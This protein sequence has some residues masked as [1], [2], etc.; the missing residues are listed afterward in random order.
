MSDKVYIVT[1]GC[2]SD[3]GIDAVFKDKSKA[4]LYCDCHRGSIIEE[5]D[6]MDDNVFTP[7]NIMNITFEIE[8]NGIEKI[9]LS[10]DRVVKENYNHI[11][12]VKHVLAF[13]DHI[14]ISLC[15]LLPDNYNEEYIQNKYIKAYRDLKAE[16]H[17]MM[18][19]YDLDI[20]KNRD[21]CAKNIEEYLKD[22]FNIEND[23][24]N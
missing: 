9:N 14:V 6:F 10:F 7:V 11:F 16:I 21:M 1:S 24:E 20:L 12:N 4:E 18:S 19:Q 3:Y 22:K 13:P 15:K 5:Y 23:E 17:Y 2:Y 8:K